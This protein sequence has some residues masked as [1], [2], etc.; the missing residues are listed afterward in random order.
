VL[1]FVAVVRQLVKQGSDCAVGR[2]DVGRRWA[3]YDVVVGDEGEHMVKRSTIRRLCALCVLLYAIFTPLLVTII[4]ADAGPSVAM[5]VP[6]LVCG[7]AGLAAGVAAW[8][9]SMSR[10]GQL[11]HNGWAALIGFGTLAGGLPG[12]LAT[13]AYAIAGPADVPSETEARI[14]G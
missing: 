10:A 7:F 9:L 2:A 4:N 3:A 14:G 5:L 6:M 11:G 8:V 13:M 12:L 1:G